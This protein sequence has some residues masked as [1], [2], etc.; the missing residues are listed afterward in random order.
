MLNW[1]L[2]LLPVLSKV[3]L[4]LQSFSQVCKT[5]SLGNTMFSG[6]P[7][8]TGCRYDPM[9]ASD[10]VTTNRPPHLP[11]TQGAVDARAQQLAAQQAGG[12][13]CR[14]EPENTAFQIPDS[15]CRPHAAQIPAIRGQWWNCTFIPLTCATLTR[16]LQVIGVS[17]KDFAIIACDT[18]LSRG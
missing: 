15:S 6:H 16:L 10:Y 14:P 7:A 3:Q 13:S 1:I 2:I 18:R 8:M 9:A 4:M 17:G 5:Q 11:G 12:Q